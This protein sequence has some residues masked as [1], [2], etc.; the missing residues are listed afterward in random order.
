M[1]V[2]LNHLTLRFAALRIL[3]PG[4]VA[5]IAASI[6]MEGQKNPVLLVAGGTLVDGYHRVAAL[7]GLARDQVTA[8]ELAVDEGE[9]LILAWQW[10]SGR[11]KSPLEE[12]WLL[13]ELVSRGETVTGLARRL[14]R[15]KSW[16]SQ[17]L[18]LVGTLPRSV[19]DAVRSSKIPTHSA[20][21]CLLPMA[22]MDPKAC[23]TLVAA[24]Y[25]PVSARQV[26]AVYGAWRRAAPEVRQRI[27]QNP[28]LFLKVEDAEKKPDDRLI[29]ALEGIT[30]GC[31]AARKLVQEGLFARANNC[32]HAWQQA[33]T[34]FVSLEEELAHDQS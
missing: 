18:G 30:R 26:E 12:A 29:V 28:M 4:R 24:L 5:R 14:Q 33:Q 2:E 27:E 15:P 10:E 8:V 7:K 22:R 23:E 21:K 3:E 16:V 1:Q 25:G 19:Q 20:M 11:K 34:A 17:R 32:K 9:A 6:H 13:A 31:H